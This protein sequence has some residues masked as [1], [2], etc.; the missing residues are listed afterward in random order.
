MLREV[1]GASEAGGGQN[2]PGGPSNAEGVGLIP[3]SRSHMSCGQKTQNIKQ[4]RYCNEFNKDF[5]NGPH[6]KKIFQKIFL[7]KN[8]KQ[9]EA[10]LGFILEGDGVPHR[11]SGQ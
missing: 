2:F 3:D 10:T 1:G 7:K 9:K 11:M 8:K 5:K 4:K 6:K